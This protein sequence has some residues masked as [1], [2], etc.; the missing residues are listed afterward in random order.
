M[1]SLKTHGCARKGVLGGNEILLL[2]KTNK[3]SPAHTGSRLRS[4]GAAVQWGWLSL[5]PVHYPSPSQPGDHPSGPNHPS[6]GADLHS[7]Y[8]GPQTPGLAWLPCKAP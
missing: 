1:L 3:S 5:V 4:R 8:P 2:A 6:A 7:L